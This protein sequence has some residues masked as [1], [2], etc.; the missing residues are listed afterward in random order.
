MRRI[1]LI[2]SIFFSAGTL[3]AQQS[4]LSYYL[5]FLSQGVDAAILGSGACK[6]VYSPNAFAALENTA[7]VPF[8]DAVFE[9]SASAGLQGV[10]QS[11]NTQNL[12]FGFS[13]QIKDNISL[14]LAYSSEIS[15]PYALVDENAMMLGT[16]Q[17][18]N[19]I[20]ATGLAWRFFPFLSM[21]ASINYAHQALAPMHANKSVALGV[22]AATVI[23]DFS[24]AASLSNLVL[25]NNQS[26]TSPASINLD[27][28]YRHVWG[29]IGLRAMAG[30][31]LYVETSALR[32]GLGL[33]CDWK[34]MMYFRVG[35]N[36][37]GASPMPD[38]LSIG[39]GAR[40]R[41][42]RCD[43]A[44][45]AGNAAYNNSLVLTLA[46]RFDKKWKNSKEEQ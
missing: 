41:G 44:Y 33:E 42:V 39:L 31:S 29:Q 16:F 46:Y 38:F 6:G 36:S 24:V 4:S 11:S 12:A 30:A 40:I 2:I 23:K 32:A 45:I 19:M 34:E 5:P 22:S 18:G 26:Y 13:S 15:S 37:G 9:L 3:F 43:I 17:P 10:A 28:D 21:G 25:I 14:S 7:R 35:A 1:I 8:S 20:L 27:A